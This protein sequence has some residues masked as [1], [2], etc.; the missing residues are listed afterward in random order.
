M[1]AQYQMPT[2]TQKALSNHKK[3]N[4]NSQRLNVQD[5]EV[6]YPLL[7]LVLVD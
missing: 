6:L 5:T 1:L 4:S 3:D 7:L 2:A